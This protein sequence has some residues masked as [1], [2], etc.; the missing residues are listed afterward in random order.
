MNQYAALTSSLLADAHPLLARCFPAGRFF[1]ATFKVGNIEGDA[2]DALSVDCNSG[3]WDDQASGER[4]DDL[5]SLYGAIHWLS[6][7]EAAQELMGLFGT[8]EVP[9]RANGAASVKANGHAE[10]SAV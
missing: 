8:R 10:P 7:A 4:G 6:R 3:R 1:G 5:I 9:A 2:G